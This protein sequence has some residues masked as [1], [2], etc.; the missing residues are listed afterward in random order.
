MAKTEKRRTGKKKLTGDIAKAVN[1]ALDKKA[2][3]VIVLDL[4]HTPAFTDYFLICSGATIAPS[5]S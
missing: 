3:D 4:R 1:A 2:A 5:G